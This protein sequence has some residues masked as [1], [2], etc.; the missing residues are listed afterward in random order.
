MKDTRNF[1]ANTIRT[2]LT[3]GLLC[4]LLYGAQAQD[5][6]GLVRVRCTVT[7]GSI[8]SKMLDF[9]Y[10][11]GHNNQRVGYGYSLHAFSSHA[12]NLPVGTRIYKK[13]H[14]QWNLLYVISKADEG[15]ELDINKAYEITHG[16]WLD[17]AH[18]EMSEQ[19]TA[20][21]PAGDDTD[22]ITRWAAERQIKMVTFAVSGK[23]LLPLMRHVRV[24][25]PGNDN[26]IRNVGFSRSMSR[27]NHYKVSYPVGS[28]I[29]ICDGPYWK[30]G[31]NYKETLVEEVTEEL[32]NY[33]V[34]L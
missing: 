24:E 4:C 23:G 34:R 9:R 20:L 5:T 33:L 6:E 10:F 32:G 31:T 21:E 3:L 1:F 30:T 14:G 7:N 18:A 12:I 26:S 19:T 13:K 29:Y 11:N 16:Q 17:A 22:P 27:F 15:R 2:L 8:R 25:L 28:K